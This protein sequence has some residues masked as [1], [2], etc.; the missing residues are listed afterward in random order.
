MVSL[1]ARVELSHI[2]AS[3]RQVRYLGDLNAETRGQEV[4][5]TVDTSPALVTLMPL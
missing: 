1:L 3:S 4:Q 2:Q 5:T